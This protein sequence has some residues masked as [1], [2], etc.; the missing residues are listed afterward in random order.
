[1][2]GYLEGVIEGVVVYKSSPHVLAN[3]V[4]HIKYATQ[5]DT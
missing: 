2:T 1:M 4:Q 5:Q 3:L